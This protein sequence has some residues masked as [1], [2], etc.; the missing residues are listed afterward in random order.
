MMSHGLRRVGTL[1]LDLHVEAARP[2][3]R[4][5]D[6]V[7]AVRG[8]DH[9]HVLQGLDPVELGQQLRDDR[10]L[11]VGGDAGPAGAEDRVHLVEEH[12]HRQALLAPLLGALEDLADL[13]LGLADVLVQQLGALHVQEVGAGV[14]ATRPLADLVGERLRDGLRDQRLAAA[15]RPVEQD[16]LR[17][18]E[19]VLVE[20]LRVQERQLDRVADVLDLALEAADVLVAD[21]GDLLEDELLD[22]LARAAARSRTMERGSN[23]TRSPARGGALEQRAREVARRAPRPRG[24]TRRPGRRPGAP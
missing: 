1:D 6:Q 21:V 19:L 10:R 2:Q 18:L 22:L 7:L 20:E 14:V 11:D 12:D 3:D 15:R 23:R 8:A 17:R 9:D 13:P 16:A 24:R 5:V 4:R